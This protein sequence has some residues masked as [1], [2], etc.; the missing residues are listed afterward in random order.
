MLSEHCATV[1]V[2]VFLNC[3]PFFTSPGEDIRVNHR[4]NSHVMWG[5]AGAKQLLE[6]DRR[7]IHPLEA[8]AKQPVSA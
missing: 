7:S 2:F 6:D 3:V 1:V 8:G 5:K 4:A